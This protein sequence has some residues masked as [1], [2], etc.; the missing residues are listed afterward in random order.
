MLHPESYL[1]RR[2]PGTEMWGS[3]PSPPGNRSSTFII[4]DDELEKVLPRVLASVCAQK[5]KCEVHHLH[6]DLLVACADDVY[7]ISCL[8]GWW[9]M[10]YEVRE[11]LC[12]AQPPWNV[13][14]MSHC[15]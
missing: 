15:R 4:Q 2:G 5:S 3:F 9:V 1:V 6:N 10:G 8:L 12:V 13:S 14:D 11:H 7:L